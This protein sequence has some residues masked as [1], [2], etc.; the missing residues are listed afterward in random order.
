M[1]DNSYLVIT[2]PKNDYS[3]VDPNRIDPFIINAVSI[4]PIPPY[5]WQAM[6]KEAKEG[7]NFETRIAKRNRRV[8]EEAV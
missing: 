7:M 5:N 3:R 1:E 4:S 2:S 6:A 8:G